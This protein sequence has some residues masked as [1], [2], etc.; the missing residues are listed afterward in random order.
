MILVIRKERKKRVVK[1]EILK[2]TQKYIRRVTRKTA[3]D[4]RDKRAKKKIK[5]KRKKN[6]KTEKENKKRKDE[7]K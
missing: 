1:K 4:I 2:E 6:S 7:K 3:I 5:Q